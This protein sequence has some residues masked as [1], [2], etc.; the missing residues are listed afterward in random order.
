MDA[1]GVAIERTKTVGR[2]VEA[3]GVAK[4]RIVA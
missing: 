1:G 2:V 3:G 4:E